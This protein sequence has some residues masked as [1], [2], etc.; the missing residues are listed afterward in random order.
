[1]TLRFFFAI[2]ISSSTYADAHHTAPM[3]ESHSVPDGFLHAGGE[4]HS[5]SL[6]LPLKFLCSACVSIEMG[7]RPNF[8]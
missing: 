1:M 5:I 4:I 2:N 3:E 6:P 7:I 8:R